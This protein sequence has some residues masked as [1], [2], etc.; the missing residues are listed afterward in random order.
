MSV[1]PLHIAA[2]GV[3]AL[4]AFPALAQAAPLTPA[5]VFMNAAPLPKLIILGLVVASVAAIVICVMKLSAGRKLSGGSAFL[6]GLRVGGP[7]AGL[8]GAALGCL[9]MSLGIANLPVTPPMNV[10]A[11]GIAEAVLLVT[12]GL[13]AGSV[14]VIAN[15][16]V[17]AKID[18]A[19]LAP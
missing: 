5:V 3:A 16:A 8:L 4:L 19:L 1:R 6:S 2:A 10:L 18:R 9:N 15:W 12:L 17:E 13:L 7:L 11:R 14:A